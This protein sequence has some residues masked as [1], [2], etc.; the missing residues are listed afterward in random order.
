MGTIHVKAFCPKCGW[1]MTAAA[2]DEGE[3]RFY[4]RALGLSASTLTHCPRCGAD[5]RGVTR[6][7]LIAKRNWP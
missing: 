7:E 3:V 2:P 5:L 6:E 1:E 4:D